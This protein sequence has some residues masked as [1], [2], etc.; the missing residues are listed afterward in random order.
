ML[1]GV[2]RN[3]G[4]LRFVPGLPIRNSIAFIYGDF[5]P[6]IPRGRVPH[7]RA[8]CQDQNVFEQQ[9]RDDF[10]GWRGTE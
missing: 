10:I 7:G 5:D 4:D 8:V 9:R 1:A 6:E 3:E 2:V